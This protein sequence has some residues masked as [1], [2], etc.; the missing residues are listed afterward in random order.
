MK[1]SNL[2]SVIISVFNGK[3]SIAES[4]QSIQQQSYKNLE[5]LVLDD[6]STDSTYKILNE[7]AKQ[8]KRIVLFKNPKNIGLTKSL[9]FLLSNCKGYFIARQDSDDISKVSRLKLQ[10][11]FLK[12]YNLD[13]CTTL[14]QSIQTGKTLH[15]KSQHFPQSLV[16][17]YKNPYIHG[18]LLTKIDTLK[19]VNFYDERFYYA[20]DYKLFS[21]LIKKKKKIKIIK[22]PLYLL[23]QKN[24]I[25]SNYYGEQQYYAECVKKGKI[26]NFEN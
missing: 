21:D 22:K 4:L 9:N 11:E 10:I 2:I 8:D 25:S 17:R 13:V 16:F 7:I 19:S 14:A 18:S 23:N 26:P 3:N 6:G 12:K 15:K 5:I 20:Q 24:N 1:N